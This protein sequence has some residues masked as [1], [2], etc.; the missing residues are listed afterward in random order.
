MILTLAAVG[1]RRPT[2]LTTTHDL[3]GPLSI[4]ASDAG[5]P[6]SALPDSAPP[7]TATP[8]ITGEGYL[9]RGYARGSLLI[10]MTIARR[11]VDDAGYA[12]WERQSQGYPPAL[13]AFPPGAASG[14]YTCGGDGGVAPCD[15]HIQTRSGFHIEVSGGGV[16]T[17]AQLDDLMTRLPL[18]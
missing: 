4:A 1:C 14:F 11:L 2:P 10:E 12:E 3:A 16:A 8:L 6:T 15:L 5:V 9:R 13:L 7:Y 17:R 18:R